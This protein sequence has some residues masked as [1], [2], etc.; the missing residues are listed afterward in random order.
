MITPPVRKAS[1]ARN[2]LLMLLGLLVFG[3]LGTWQLN[4]SGERRAELA[5]FASA[6]AALPVTGLHAVPAGGDNRRV[7]LMGRYEADRQVLLDSM[8]HEG[9]RGYHV[10]TPLHT[11]PGMVLVNR[12]FVAGDPDRSRLPDLAVGEELRE[13]T[14]MAAP[15][16]RRGMRL[17]DSGADTSWPRRLV[18]PTAGELREL[19]G[20]SLPDFQLLLDSSEPDGYVRAWRPYGLEPE[21]HLAYAVQWYGLAAAAAGIWLAVTLRR[22]RTR[23]AN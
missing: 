22:G 16:F 19:L 11:G 3:S 17:E 4:R 2:L 20:E 7:R 5:A 8:T 23:D 15:Y 14:G 1:A 13:V 6:K 9:L 12:G 21:R 18:Y 10:L